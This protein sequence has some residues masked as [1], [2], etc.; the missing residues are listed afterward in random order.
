MTAVFIKEKDAGDAHAWRKSHVST[1]RGGGRLQ[2]QGERP[3][4]K[5]DLAG[6]LILDFQSTEW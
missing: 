5:A 2:S 4:K 1:Q 3:Q 6:P